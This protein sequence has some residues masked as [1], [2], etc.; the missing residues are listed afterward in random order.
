MSDDLAAAFG[1][2]PCAP[3]APSR[4]WREVPLFATES[5]AVVRCSHA[6]PRDDQSPQ[7]ALFDA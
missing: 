2:E 4:H 5:P 1:F 6:R 3:L 7:L